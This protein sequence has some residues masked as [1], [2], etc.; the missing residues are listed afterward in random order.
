MTYIT[1][2]PLKANRR[3]PLYV[4]NHTL[5]HYLQNDLHCLQNAFFAKCPGNCKE[6]FDICID[7]AILWVRSSVLIK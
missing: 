4:G 5:N 6:L 3:L 1:Y 7:Y 2:K